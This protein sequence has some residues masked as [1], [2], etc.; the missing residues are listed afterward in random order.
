[1]TTQ[2]NNAQ[3]SSSRNDDTQN[4]SGV[5]FHR[6][7]FSSKWV[8]IKTGFHQNGFSSK[9]VFIKWLVHR[10]HNFI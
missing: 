8:F 1:M 4:Y 6:N 5:G 10:T 7:G 2:H 9:Q 3:Y